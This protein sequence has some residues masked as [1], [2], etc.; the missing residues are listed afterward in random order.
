MVDTLTSWDFDSMSLV[1]EGQAAPDF[2]LNSVEGVE[3]KL[4]QFKGDKP[5]VLVF[6]YG[7]T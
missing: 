6:V 5:V 2:T 1:K 4:S 3:Y 7:D